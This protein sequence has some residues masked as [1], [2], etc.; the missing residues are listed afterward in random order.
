MNANLLI[1]TDL[2]RTLIPNGSQPESPHARPLFASLTQREEVALAYVSGR[3]RGLVLDAISEFDLPVPD[4]VIGDVG[5]SLYRVESGGDWSP[6]PAWAAHIGKDWAG[7]SVDDLKAVLA[8]V[9][10]LRL[11]EASKQGRFKLS[12]Y[13]PEDADS[14]GLIQEL[15]GRL[16]DQGIRA[17]L[18]WS[19]DEAVGVGL[20][21]VLPERATKYHAVEFLVEQEGFEIERT[22]FSGDSGNDLEPLTSPLPAVLVANAHPAVREEAV[23][24]SNERGLAARLYCARGGFLGMN[25]N[26]A[27]GILEGV[28]H[29]HPFV[30]AWLSEAQRSS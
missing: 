20:L 10:H 9:P 3:H 28:A 21:D 17:S 8:G 5:T 16:A 1:C 23:R 7:A 26:Y 13:A 4:F 2:D 18:I 29:Y 24:V 27:A 30:Q 6:Q 15:Q 12:F 25:G 11:Q 22:V 19:I 14:G